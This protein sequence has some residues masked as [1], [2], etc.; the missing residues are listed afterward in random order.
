MKRK[1]LDTIQTCK[2]LMSCLANRCELLGR[3]RKRVNTSHVPGVDDSSLADVGF[4]LA[5]LTSTT[6][7]ME[8]FG[9]SW[10]LPRASRFATVL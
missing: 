4:Y 3:K 9:L 5:S 8:L 2:I 7:L 6:A 1:R 10:R